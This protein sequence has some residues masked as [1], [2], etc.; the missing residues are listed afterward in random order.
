MAGRVIFHIDLNAFFASAEIL[1]NTALE[2]QPLVVAGL[3]R[4]SVVSTA[5]YEA[6][7]YGIHSAMPL[8]MALE[9]CPDLV[10]VQGN[11]AWYEELSGRFFSYLRK[12]TPY[13]EP[14]ENKGQLAEKTIISNW[15][16]DNGI[17][18]Q[19]IIKYNYFEHQLHYM[20]LEYFYQI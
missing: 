1:K 5:S 16:D 17:K 9:K 20:V 2:G 14:E 7:A 13:I 12:F 8:H 6:R 4:R 10:V 18:K 3:H 11:Y 15:E 19:T